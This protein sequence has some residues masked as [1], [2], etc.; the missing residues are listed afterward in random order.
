MCFLLLLCGSLYCISIMC[1]YILACSQWLFPN[2]IKV[3][4]K[5]EIYTILIQL[6]FCLSPFFPPPFALHTLNLSPFSTL[7][8]LLSSPLP[9]SCR[10]QSQSDYQ[11]FSGSGSAEDEYLPIRHRSTKLDMTRLD[12][13]PHRPN[14]QAWM[15]EARSRDSFSS[16]SGTQKLTL[17]V[18][19]FVSCFINFFADTIN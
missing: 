10:D 17:H 14:P 3:W 1:T 5:N 12:P 8:I 16:R 6:F 15:D 19:T 4:L 7:V 11:E 9:L 13:P 18:V 2:W